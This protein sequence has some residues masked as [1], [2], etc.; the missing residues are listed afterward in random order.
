M[1][2]LLVS[3]SMSSCLL[4][5]FDRPRALLHYC[6]Y[7]VRKA[8]VAWFSLVAPQSAFL[9]TEHAFTLHKLS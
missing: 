7:D 4:T 3:S 8:Q 1:Y 6:P 5:L 9:E 2:N